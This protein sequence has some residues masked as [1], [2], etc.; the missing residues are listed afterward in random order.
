MKYPLLTVI[1]SACDIGVHFQKSFLHQW[2]QNYS[3]FFFY[4]A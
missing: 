2:F 3:H 4:D 1:L